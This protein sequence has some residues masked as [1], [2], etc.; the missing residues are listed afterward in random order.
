MATMT[1]HHV[2]LFILILRLELGGFVKLHMA[3]W[4]KIS[5]VLITRQTNTP[6]G[7][8][9]LA[10]TSLWLLDSLAN[11]SMYLFML[12]PFATQLRKSLLM[13]RKRGSQQ[14]NTSVDCSNSGLRRHENWKNHSSTSLP[15]SWQ[16][17]LVPNNSIDQF[18]SVRLINFIF[19]PC[20]MCYAL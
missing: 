15:F 19:S 12:N 5:C 16:L 13:N 9:V 14:D 2:A 1:N 4:S 7:R 17:Q 20:A 3:A 8:I 18:H 6:P 11:F 10:S